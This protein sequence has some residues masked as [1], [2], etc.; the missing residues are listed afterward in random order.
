MRKER[1][2]GPVAFDSAITR[3]AFETYLTLRGDE[4]MGQDATVIHDDGALWA[5]D[6]LDEFFADYR[7][8]PDAVHLLSVGDSKTFQFTTEGPRCRLRV[9]LPERAQIE[10]V[11]RIFEEAEP[12][13]RIEPIAQPADPPRIFV[14]HGHDGQWRLLRDHLRD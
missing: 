3:R 11:F 13:S 2:F 14:G 6:N 8:F 7:R 1:T 12:E 5:Y 10:Q 9:E 4:P